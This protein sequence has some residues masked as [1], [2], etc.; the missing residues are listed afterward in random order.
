MESACKKATESKGL[1]DSKPLSVT[2]E[3]SFVKDDDEP[4]AFVISTESPTNYV[5]VNSNQS[6][7]LYALHNSFILNSSATIHCCN[8][9]TRFHNLTLAAVDNILIARNDHI[10]IKAF[11]DVYIA[12]EGPYR[13]KRILLQ[14]V[15]YVPT[16]HTSVVSFRKFIK[17][18]VH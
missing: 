10:L 11:G 13:L 2:S 9:Y 14:T 4:G 8:T 17:Q 6:T 16:L 3:S 15:A 12:V 18:G 7:T 1:K 5:T